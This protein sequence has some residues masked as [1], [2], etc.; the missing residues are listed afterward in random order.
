MTRRYVCWTVLAVAAAFI[1]KPMVANWDRP[2]PVFKPR[3][4]MLAGRGALQMP[5]VRPGPPG[6]LLILG[7]SYAGGWKLPPVAGRQILNRGVSGQES[8]EVLARFDRDAL[9]AHPSSIILWGYIND[10]FRAPR[11][12][13]DKALARA[14]GSF[15]QMIAK[16]RAAGIDVIVAT[17]VTIRPKDEWSETIASWVGWALGKQSYQDY[18]NG[19]VLALNSWLRELAK[20]EHLLLLDLEPQLSDARNVRRKEFSNAD[21]SHITPAG[22]DALNAYAVPTLEQYFRG[23]PT[24]QP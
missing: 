2:G 1:G 20:R 8:W 15:E 9:E 16:A 19:H 23:K 7:A 12:Q 5:E 24:R 21:G 10:V 18:I 22:Y 17:E 13:M 4:P 14:R 3:P 11:D 6:P